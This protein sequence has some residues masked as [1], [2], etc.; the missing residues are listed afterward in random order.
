M[1]QLLH[2]VSLNYIDDI[3]QITNSWIP[4]PPSVIITDVEVPAEFYPEAARHIQ[5]NLGPVNLNRVGKTWWQW[6]RPGSVV[7]G[8]WVE[9]KSDY[10][11]RKANSNVGK[12]IM[13]YVHGGA[14]FLGAA[15]HVPQFQRHARK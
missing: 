10:L 4:Y 13:L 2:F 15:G 1:R 8:E 9:M 12:K 7:R 3:Q 11:E 6:R 5:A 14:Y